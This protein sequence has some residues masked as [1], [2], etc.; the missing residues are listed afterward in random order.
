VIGARVWHAAAICTALLISACTNPY[1]L[2]PRPAPR[3]E[4]PPEP[5][6]KPPPPAVKKPAAPRRAPVHVP[7]AAPLSERDAP[8]HP[9]DI[10]VDVALTPDPEPVFEPPSRGGNASS[11]R[12]FGKKYFTLETAE[13]YKERGLASWYGK[14][15]HG[16]KTSNGEIYDMFALTAAHKALP[17]PTYARVTNLKNGRQ[18]IVRV[19]DRGPFHPGR[20][21]DL[22]YAAA[23][24][25]DT[26]G[27]IVEVEVEALTPSNWPPSGVTTENLASLETSA[28][29]PAERTP[30]IPSPQTNVRTT[31]QD[32]VLQ[33]AAFSDPINA[34]AT[35]ETLSSKGFTTARVER[36]TLSEGKV[37]HRVLIGP[38]SGRQ[39]LEEARIRAR[40]AGFSPILLK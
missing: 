15:F 16:R 35:R 32:Q 4:P 5:V 37:I 1:T 17:L 14:K 23:A 21:I 12:V 3:S 33:I 39:R 27:D 11:Y 7:G 9:D 2:P 8:P 18:V 40:M 26:I 24:R 25:L 28:A 30:Q 36:A 34:A 20:I 22:S 10:P 31:P 38:Y 19:N 6:K 13:G 29:A